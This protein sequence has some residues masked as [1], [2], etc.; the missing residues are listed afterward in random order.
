[1]VKFIELTNS[2]RSQWALGAIAPDRYLVAIVFML[3]IFGQLI[4]FQYLTVLSNPNKDA[5]S[6]RVEA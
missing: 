2:R 4:N 3:M 1:M 5:A 6:V